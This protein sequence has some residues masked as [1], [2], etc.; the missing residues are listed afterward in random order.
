MLF[1]VSS[2]AARMSIYGSRHFS[3]LAVPVPTL[4]TQNEEIAMENIMEWANL[5]PLERR[6]KR[7]EWWISADVNFSSP[8][9]RNNYR[10]RAQRFVSA[11]SVE[12][13]DR[14]PV[15]LPVDA[16]PAYIA[17]TDLFT[18]INDYDKAR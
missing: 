10:E 6:K 5:T 18:V 1:K 3:E 13:P 4:I 16:W 7:Y 12:K 9:A 8:E 15:V 14:V 17:G 2:M 11:Y